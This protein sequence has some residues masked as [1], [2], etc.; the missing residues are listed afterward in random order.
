MRTTTKLLTVMGG[1]VSYVNKVKALFGANL[2]AYWPQLE[3]SGTV[4][5][6]V[7]GN[8]RN[9]AYTGVDLANAAGPKGGMHPYFDGT[10]DYN[11]LFSL[12][13]QGVFPKQLGGLAIW[14]KIDGAAVWTD[15]VYREGVRLFADSS[16]YVLID[17][18]ASDGTYRL[19]YNA[20]GTAK[21]LTPAGGG[22]L[23]WVHLGITWTLAGDA[24][25]GYINGVKTGETQTGLGTWGAPNIGTTTSLVG[26]STNV[27]ALVWKGWLGH[28]VLTNR[29][30]TPT[31]MATLA[32]V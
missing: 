21:S 7:S 29:V 5:A 30:I 15:G 12:G 17:K 18:H 14:A 31:E 24:V 2:V 27:P 32:G 4:A 28:C 13:L 11:N 23:T 19:I 25:I 26:A 6:D 20:N 16:N 3:T 8:A 1:G 9:G 10:N 22:S